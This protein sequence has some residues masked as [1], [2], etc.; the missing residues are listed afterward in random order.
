MAG[1]NV[2]VSQACA[3]IPRPSGALPVLRMER[4]QF[5]RNFRLGGH[6]GSA[7]TQ[8]GLITALL[9]PSLHIRS[10]FIGHTV[11]CGTIQPLA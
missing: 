4:R 11:I 2:R 10:S 5:G 6:H 8:N 7:R 3:S 9:V 1:R